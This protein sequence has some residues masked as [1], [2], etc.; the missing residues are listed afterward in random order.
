MKLGTL[1][2]HLFAFFRTLLKDDFHV[3]F[4]SGTVPLGTAVLLYYSMRASVECEISAGG[5]IY[6]DI[7]IQIVSSE[8]R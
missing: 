3:F 1:L 2:D 6:S 7:H 4:L 8:G 5:W